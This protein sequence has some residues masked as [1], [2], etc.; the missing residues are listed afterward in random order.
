LAASHSALKL[1]KEARDTCTC[2]TQLNP[3]FSSTFS[4]DDPAFTG[5]L[6]SYFS[7]DPIQGDLKG[8]PERDF[9]SH[10]W[11]Q[12]NRGFGFNVQ[13]PALVSGEK[14]NVTLGFAEV[15]NPL[16]SIGK[17]VMDISVN[18]EPFAEDLDV[19]E[20][21]GC[22]SALV[23]SKE[24]TLV[25]GA[26]GFNI[27]FTAS[28]NNPMISIIE[29]SRWTTDETAPD[30][31][32]LDLIYTGDGPLK[33]K[34][35]ASLDPSSVTVVNTADLALDS[36]SFNINALIA[37]GS[38]AQSITF[39]NGKRESNAPFAYCGNAGST[40]YTC[41]DLG[42]GTHTITA[43]A[44]TGSSVV[45]TFRIETGDAVEPTTSPSAPPT[46]APPTAA[47]T[48][49]PTPKPTSASPTECPCWDI[50]LLANKLPIDFSMEIFAEDDYNIFLANDWSGPNYA[51]QMKSGL[52][53]CT[54][55][56]PD[57]N[58]YQGKVVT[59][60][61]SSEAFDVCKASLLE[62]GSLYLAQEMEEA[63][64]IGASDGGSACPCWGGDLAAAR[65]D[66]SFYG[67]DGF[68]CRILSIRTGMAEYS[69]D[70]RA[71]RSSTSMDPLYSA[72]DFFFGRG[73]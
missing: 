26:N 50:T 56:T 3:T 19:F 32:R 5:A 37:V 58:D 48:S 38:T 70:L 1:I 46:T 31:S 11:G 20:E 41:N 6:A 55:P 66:L 35:V 8:F 7:G 4:G 13:D 69:S 62:R 34:P 43:T 21:V 12:G 15:Y 51:V 67:V 2:T 71:H 23:L 29:V 33:N 60:L 27:F 44:D 36:L 45:V 42:E 14:Y 30:I 72:A 22:H 47:P 73:R 39:S 17:R 40:F 10:R 49:G 61:I 28:A 25:E 18:G 24:F 16:C 53:E 57:P 65:P 63:I 52:Y 68:V 59:Q 64:D 54:G 9:Q